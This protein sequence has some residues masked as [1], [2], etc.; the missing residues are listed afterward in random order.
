MA[1]RALLTPDLLTQM[2]GPGVS[3]P[4]SGIPA[5]WQCLAFF[6]TIAALFTRQPD[7]FLH[8]Q[9]YAEDG[10]FWYAQAY[11]YGRLKA[12]TFQD[13]GY[14]NT[15]PRLVAAITLLFP[16]R[17]APL[18]MNS[19][20]IVLQALPV[21]ALLSAR[22]R[23]W[24]PLPLRMLMAVIYVAL[25]NSA[26]IH[27]V[28]TNAQW[29]YIILELLLVFGVAPRSVLAKAAD[30]VLF[31]I[32]SVSGPF[33]IV[34]LPLALFFWWRRRTP[35]TL[36]CSLLLGLGGTLQLFVYLTHASGRPRLELGASPAL[37]LKFFGLDVVTG[38][39]LALHDVA[40]RW[41]A[42]ALIPLGIFGLLFILAGF[43]RAS[44]PLRLMIVFTALCLVLELHSP[45]ADPSQPAWQILLRS[46]GNRYWYFPML[47]F[48]WSAAWFVFEERSL[49]LRLA[50]L[51][52]LLPLPLGIARDWKHAPFP[53]NHFSLYAAR[54][55]LASP[56]QHVII[57]LYP[58][59]WSMELV[60]HQK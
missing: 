23:T 36:L 10:K 17:F 1:S 45:L 14:L 50:G 35:W 7:M 9:F 24:G 18:L 51:C 47:V 46:Y 25:P 3:A 34:L 32:G 57:Q 27:V 53:D 12:L 20:G 11:N 21:M 40:Y 13:G 15:L 6:L 5:A 30:V 56:G 42:S 39:I 52:V 37:F 2:E 4:R 58:E 28:L 55:E 54:F 33:S 59:D 31:L 43:F 49:V 8:P 26:E 60:K 44:L 16:F 19:F 22:C 41:P 48:F 38:G 29:H